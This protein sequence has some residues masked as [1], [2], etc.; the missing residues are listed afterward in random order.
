M[1]EPEQGTGIHPEVGDGDATGG[2]EGRRGADGEPEPVAV[3]LEVVDRRREAPVARG[4]LLDRERPVPAHGLVE[5]AAGDRHRHR[6]EASRDALAM[7][8]PPETA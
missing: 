3:L 8:R 2:Q 1:N 4:E 5:A 6:A 7:Q